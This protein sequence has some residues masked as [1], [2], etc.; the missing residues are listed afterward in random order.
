MSSFRFP[1]R[2]G[3]EMRVLAGAAIV[4]TIMMRCAS[5]DAEASIAPRSTCIPSDMAAPV[6]FG[7]DGQ[8]LYYNSS[9]IEDIVREARSCRFRKIALTV[10]T[11]GRDPI[12]AGH[13][14]AML[15]SMLVESRW[16]RG[17]IIIDTQPV[18]LAPSGTDKFGA[19]TAKVLIGFADPDPSFVPPM[20][21][22][23]ESCG[24]NPY[25]KL[26]TCE[27]IPWSTGGASRIPP[28]PSGTEPLRLF[29][30]AGQSQL[31]GHAR[32]IVAEAWHIFREENFRIISVFGQASP[33][34]AQ[35]LRLAR[36]AAVRTA[37]IHMGMDP[38]RIVV[39][40]E[41]APGA[42]PDGAVFYRYVT[43]DFGD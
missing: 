7:A 35:A 23:A 5:A 28:P 16:P 33:D 26:H 31:D 41:P 34:E 42:M 3:A 18:G 17:A 40:Q 11:D 25:T 14:A 20:M 12:A 9:A 1:E 37:L 27:P 2:S 4:L 29:F 24:R 21:N 30:N 43:I 36:A 13:R 39:G 32:D 38:S 6:D 8:P 19:W 10:F 15:K 22:P